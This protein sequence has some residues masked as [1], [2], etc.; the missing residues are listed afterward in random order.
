M[1]RRKT[2]NLK[3]WLEFWLPQFRDVTKVVLRHNDSYMMNCQSFGTVD[4]YPASDRLLI[5]GT[6]EWKNKGL[7]ILKKE[8][9][10]TF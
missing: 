6:N 7:A 2:N 8:F 10:I 3:E 4:F 9:D 5:R 1:K